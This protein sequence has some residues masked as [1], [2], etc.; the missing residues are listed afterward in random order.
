[1]A[2]FLNQADLENALASVERDSNDEI[3]V[4]SPYGF[5]IK[6]V[7]G[8]QYVVAMIKEEAEQL[9]PKNQ[10]IGNCFT[11]SGGHACINNTCSQTCVM[12]FRPPTNWICCCT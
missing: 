12:I 10:N 6:K 9:C 5:T 2:E 3:I 7:D 11:P 1:M 8:K 4:L